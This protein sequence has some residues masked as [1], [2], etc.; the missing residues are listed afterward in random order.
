MLRRPRRSR[1]CC[2]FKRW[3]D[4]IFS[5]TSL[6]LCPFNK[7]LCVQNSLQLLI[8][9]NRSSTQTKNILLCSSIFNEISTY[10]IKKIFGYRTIHLLPSVLQIFSPIVHIHIECSKHSSRNRI[11]AN[12][13]LGKDKCIKGYALYSILNPN[14][15]ELCVIFS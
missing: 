4:G 7:I 10:Q 6:H 11:N 12:L 2:T 15:Y 3:N 5:V 9:V 14:H 8:R 1:R 13:Y